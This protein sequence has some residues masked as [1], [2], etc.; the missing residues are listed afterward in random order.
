MVSPLMLAWQL[1]LEAEHARDHG[2]GN[3]LRKAEF[4][5]KTADAIPF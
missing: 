3:I 1:L 2:P 5:E 4:D